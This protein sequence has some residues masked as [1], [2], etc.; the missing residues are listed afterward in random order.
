MAHINHSRQIR[1]CPTLTLEQLFP[2]NELSENFAVLFGVPQ[3]RTE[4]A[5]H[6]MQRY[7]GKAG[8]V[9]IHDDPAMSNELNRLTERIPQVNLYYANRNLS[10]AR[11]YDPLYGLNERAIT[12]IILPVQKNG[13]NSLDI[14]S[15]RAR[16]GDYLS[17]MK[18]QFNNNPSIFGSYPYNLDLL[19]QLTQMPFSQLQ[20][21]V[22]NYLPSDMSER[23]S[24]RLSADSIQQSVF[25]SVQNF[26]SVAEEFLWSPSNA[27]NHSRLSIIETVKNG[28]II[29][30]H[31]PNSNPDLL[32]Y[33]YYELESLINARIPFL[34]VE[35][36]LSLHNSAKI[37]DCF[38]GEHTQLNYRTGII[39]QSASSL[40]GSEKD[41]LSKITSQYQ[42]IVVL[43]CSSNA[44]AEPFSAS[45]GTYFRKVTSRNFQSHR[46]PFSI[47]SSHG[48]GTQTNEQEE[49]NI[50]PEELVNLGNGAMLC[51]ASHQLPVLVQNLIL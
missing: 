22:L 8:I 50:R 31:I 25:D 18:Y 14:S 34:L 9:F 44:E 4:I 33:I 51:G 1:L 46:R 32:N 5:L 35:S 42:E 3:Q 49:R 47:F 17:I 20:A 23:L 39:S 15:A 10:D 12:D 40:L 43:R 26:R 37:S 27:A 24:S 19:V 48:G 13:T 36:G 7:V 28:D 45:A 41:D 38:F 29:S 30:V 2:Q 6:S 16:L 21:S 11:I